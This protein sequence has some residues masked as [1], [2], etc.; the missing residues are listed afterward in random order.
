[1]QGFL[2]V[3]SMDSTCVGFMIPPRIHEKLA[4]LVTL[5]EMRDSG[6]SRR[7]KLG[8]ILSRQHPSPYRMLSMLRLMCRSGLCRGCAVAF[9]MIVD[10]LEKLVL[11]GKVTHRER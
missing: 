3:T 2:K 5:S 4:M 8:C 6:P 10:S 11:D 1:M 7:R 9:D